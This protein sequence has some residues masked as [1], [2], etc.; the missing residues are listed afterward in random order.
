MA[1]DLPPLTT[2]SPAPKKKSLSS[3][4]LLLL[5]AL[6]GE[7]GGNYYI[8]N[9]NRPLVNDLYRAGKQDSRSSSMLTGVSVDATLMP[10]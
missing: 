8:S 3:L 7:E 2:P 4:L 10:P 9:I 6:R 1:D 5:A